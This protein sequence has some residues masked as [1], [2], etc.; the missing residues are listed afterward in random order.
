MISRPV[1]RPSKKS[2]HYEHKKMSVTQNS[3]DIH[4]KT[5]VY[6]NL[7][8]PPLVGNHLRGIANLKSRERSTGAKRSRQLHRLQRP[9]SHIP[10]DGNEVD[11]SNGMPYIVVDEFQALQ[12][13]EDT[14]R[15]FVCPLGEQVKEMRRGH[16]REYE[17]EVP[18]RREEVP[19]HRPG[20][21]KSL[22]QIPFDV[23]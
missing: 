1:P 3:G 8:R 5:L 14:H 9:L 7:H 17:R 12:L 10:P 11:Q 23:E 16:A 19:A 22:G 4:D 21:R 20:G 15:V 18:N 2:I 13:R 6:A